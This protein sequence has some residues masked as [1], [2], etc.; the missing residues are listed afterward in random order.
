MDVFAFVTHVSAVMSQRATQGKYLAWPR[1]D[2]L[3]SSI[4]L[5]EALL[6]FCLYLLVLACLVSVSLSTAANISF[7]PTEAN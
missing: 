5:P 2:F 6:S 7:V 3:V 4:S 1:T